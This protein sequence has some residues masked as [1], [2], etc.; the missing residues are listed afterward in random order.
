MTL[1]TLRLAAILLPASL[2][3]HEL[4]YAL[5]GGGF[6]GAHGYLELLVPI[7]VAL[8]ASIAFATLVA[9]SLGAPG[10]K[11][12]PFAPFAL[13]G[14][15]IGIFVVQ[16]L[17]EAALLGGGVE[18]LAASA[19]VSWLAPP[20]ALLLG[21]LASGLI[22]A[23]ERT[24]QLLATPPRRDR[25]GIPRTPTAPLAPADPEIGA[26]ACTG[27]SFGFARRPPPEAA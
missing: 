5:A 26:A 13:A 22:V 18:G 10:G 19:A 17:A 21:A 6:V 1:R 12:S 9:P 16:E 27:L 23:L 14:A 24:G 2:V 8:A 15:L 20:I 7:S 3:L 11:P 25:T 4:A